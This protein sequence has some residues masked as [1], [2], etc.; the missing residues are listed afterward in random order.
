M[1]EYSVYTI[2]EGT[3]YY[4]GLVKL[5]DGSPT[6]VAFKC[7][8]NIQNF[9]FRKLN[10]DSLDQL[11]VAVGWMLSESNEISISLLSKESIAIMKEFELEFVHH[12]LMGTVKQG[13]MP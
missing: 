11:T 7:D 10:V 4:R 13:T 2:L 5:S 8:K 3:D 9:R 1:S 6:R 12:S